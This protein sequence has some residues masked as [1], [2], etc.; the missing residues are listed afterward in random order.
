[1]QERHGFAPLGAVDGPVRSAILGG[2][3]V[4]LYGLPA[5]A[6]RDELSQVRDDYAISGA[7]PSRLA[8]GFV[9]RS[10]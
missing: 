4:A 5:T 1:M 9:G 10:T 7:A 8:Y 2:N 3:A 6:A